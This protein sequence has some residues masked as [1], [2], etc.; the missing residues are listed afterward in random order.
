MY[1][2]CCARF[3]CNAC[4][5]CHVCNIFSVIHIMSCHAMSC[6]T[7]LCVMLLTCCHAMSCYVMLCH[8]MSCYV[9]ICTIYQ[10]GIYQ[11]ALISLAR[12]NLHPKSAPWEVRLTVS[13]EAAMGEI[14]EALARSVR[15]SARQNFWNFVDDRNFEK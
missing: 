10:F 2:V 1:Y 3:V 9:C 13:S 4:H 8:A 11:T 5:V 14:L 7:M 12:R 6:H 15:H